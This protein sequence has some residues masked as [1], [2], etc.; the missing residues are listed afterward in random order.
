MRTQTTAR[1]S[2]FKETLELANELDLF[3]A[4]PWLDGDVLQ[5]MCLRS[6]F[7]RSSKPLLSWWCICSVYLGCFALNR[8]HCPE[9]EA[10]GDVSVFAASVHGAKSCTSLLLTRKSISR[11]VYAPVKMSRIMARSSKH[12]ETSGRLQEM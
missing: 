5:M 11:G 6:C 1:A 3:P 8:H 9:T 2:G 12:V 7:G 10:A 4:K